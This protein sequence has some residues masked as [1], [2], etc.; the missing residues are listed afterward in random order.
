MDWVPATNWDVVDVIP[1]NTQADSPLM[2]IVDQYAAA[3]VVGQVEVSPVRYFVHRIVGQWSAFIA[4]PVTDG[5]HH[6]RIWP[7]YVDT[8]AGPVVVTPDFIDDAEGANP[9]IWHERKFFP[10]DT[11]ARS[12]QTTVHPWWQSVDI[13][14]KQVIEKYHVPCLSFFNSDAT[15][16]MVTQAWFRLLV[17]PLT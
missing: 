14:P 17:T 1:A 6:M 7:A 9:R 12:L 8:S 11:V 3:D 2:D 13:K 5:A 10:Q 16:V 15:Q 4:S